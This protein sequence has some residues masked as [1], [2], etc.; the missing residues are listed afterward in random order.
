MKTDAKIIDR[1]GVERCGGE[2][3]PPDR[4]ER[5]ECAQIAA[6]FVR[7]RRSKS[8]SKLVI[9]TRKT[10]GWAPGRAPLGVAGPV[11]QPMR[12]PPDWPFVESA[13]IRRTP[14]ASPLRSTH[15]LPRSVWSAAHSAALRSW[16]CPANAF[17]G[18]DE[19]K[20]H[21]LPNASRS[22]VTN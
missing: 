12:Q 13:G 8:G 20:L 7:S 2:V 22:S 16:G 10:S 14:E 3:P 11:C 4:A 17:A 18:K 21:A 15:P 19:S 1:K 5:M 6:A 9:L